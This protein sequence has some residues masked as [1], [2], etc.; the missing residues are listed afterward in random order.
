[1]K[2]L[3]VN[4]AIRFLNEKM[5]IDPKLEG[6]DAISKQ[7]IYNA[8]SKGELKRYGPKHILQIDEQELERRFLGFFPEGE[9]AAK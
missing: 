5:Q 3:T 4:G 2:L 8:V 7:T 6:R 9:I 1:M